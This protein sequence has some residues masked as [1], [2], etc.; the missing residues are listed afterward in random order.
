MHIIVYI[1]AIHNSH[2]SILLWSSKLDHRHSK[3]Y[4]WLDLPLEKSLAVEPDS[5]PESQMA[6]GRAWGFRL[7]H[8]KKQG[9]SQNPATIG[10]YQTCIQTLY[11]GVRS[12][13]CYTKIACSCRDEYLQQVQIYN[14]CWWRWYEVVNNCKQNQILMHSKSHQRYY[15][16]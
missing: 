13:D 3:V 14:T 4:I 10:C 2:V 16:V 7:E 1:H 12:S 6:N 8:S 15:F 5:Q 9:W 11:N